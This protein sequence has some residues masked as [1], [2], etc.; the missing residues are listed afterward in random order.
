[1]AT[2]AKIPKERLAEY[3]DT[4]TKRFVRGRPKE[5]ADIE[6]LEGE[7]GDQ[8]VA[9]GARL[10]G[11]TYDTGSGA[12]EIELEGGD[13]RRFDVGELW[14]VEEPDGF[15]SALEISGPEG[16]VREVIT[17]KRVALKRRDQ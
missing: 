4:F 15:V 5:V 6:V 13:H 14:V 12:L 1:M 8:Y 7:L 9:E 16:G 10:V 11:I 2:T 3:F 17:V